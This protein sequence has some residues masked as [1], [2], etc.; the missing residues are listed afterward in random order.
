MR[1]IGTV[2]IDTER[3]ALRRFMQSDLEDLYRNYGSD[4]LVYK[5]VSFA[6]CTTKEG[7][8]KFIETH[9]QCY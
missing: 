7:C 5:Y 2:R 3:L 6:P 8:E 1:S 4:P 9:I